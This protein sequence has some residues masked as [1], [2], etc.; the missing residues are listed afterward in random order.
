MRKRRKAVVWSLIGLS[1][2]IAVVLVS[3]QAPRHAKQPVYNGRTLEQWLDVGAH[4]G[5]WGV[6]GPRNDG[7]GPTPQQLREAEESVRAIGTNAIPTL[8]EWI[9]YRASPFRRSAKDV[10][11]R[12]PSAY[13]ARD[14]LLFT[15][16]G[17]KHEVRS[18]LGDMGFAI[19]NTNALPA[20]EALSKLLRDSKDAGEPWRQKYF[21][22]ILFTV[23]NTPSQ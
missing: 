16:A 23:T 22:T 7:K 11:A 2:L 20:R 8:L 6:W 3:I 5:K 15:V 1:I 10:I 13:G 9:S 4:S 14:V 18:E 12:V 21:E 19:L 17:Y